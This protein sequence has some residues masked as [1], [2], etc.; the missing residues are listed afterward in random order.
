MNQVHFVYKAE[1]LGVSGILEDRLE[2]GLVIVEISL[3]FAALHVEDVD[4][5]FDITKYAFSLT[6]DVAFHERFLPATKQLKND[7]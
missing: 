6:G 1:D 2:A 7:F 5:N 4:E 3:K